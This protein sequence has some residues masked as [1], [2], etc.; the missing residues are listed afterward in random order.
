[1]NGFYSFHIHESY[2]P[3]TIP[4]ERLAEY[5]AALARLLGETAS[6]HFDEVIEGS[7][8]VQARVD[9]PAQPK[10]RERV[11]SVRS[12]VAPADVRKAFDELDEMLR[13]DNA[14]GALEDGSAVIIPFPGKRRPEPVIYGPFRQ[15]GTLDGQVYRLG[16][17]DETKHVHI[18]DGKR[19]FSCLTATEAMAIRLREHLFGAVLRFH[20]V[21][22]WFRHDNGTW[23]LKAFRVADFEELE[24]APLETVVERLRK[25]GPGELGQ[26]ADP[27]SRLLRDRH[28]GEAPN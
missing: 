6:V 22:T 10:V 9:E 24:D 21:G 11:E 19:R 14:Y 26:S 18:R 3:A 13:R 16:G 17:E 27:V 7:T 20:G 5:M 8:A 28:G 1:M 2:S 23:E 25:A 15:E 4:M 12:G